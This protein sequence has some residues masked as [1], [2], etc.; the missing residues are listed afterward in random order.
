MIVVSVVFAFTMASS[1]SPLVPTTSAEFE[2]WCAFP[3]ERL[4]AVAPFCV[5]NNF[6]YVD[7]LSMMLYFASF[8]Q[9]G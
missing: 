8:S 3:A 1:Q 4:K 6:S 5:I 2:A 9:D 7:T